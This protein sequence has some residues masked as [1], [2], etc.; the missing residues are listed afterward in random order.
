MRQFGL[1][2]KNISYSFS[3]KYFSEKFKKEGIT[4]CSYRIFDLENLNGIDD[5]I[6]T[7]KL[8][9]FNVTIPYKEKIL[10]FLDELSP[11]AEE[12]GAVNCV[13]LVNEKKIGHNTD[14]YGFEKSLK[15]LLK[16]QHQK[17]LILGDGGASKSVK[18]VFKKLKIEYLTVHRKGSFF[19]SDLTKE[20]IENH[21]LIV[22]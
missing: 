2:G 7:E 16:P 14:S 5:F 3:E 22:N 19:Y 9:G 18:Y 12:I 6:Q 20:I 15:T 10:P 8:K 17:A 1:I 21:L 4:D 13:H 11:E